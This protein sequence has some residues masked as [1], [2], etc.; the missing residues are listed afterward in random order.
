MKRAL[1][2]LLLLPFA[3]A[4]F[5]LQN[6]DI[7]VKLGEDGVASV[8]ERINLVIFGDYARQLYE[9]GYNRNT[10]SAWQEI[11]NVTEIKAHVSARS[12]DI[13]NLLILP[14][15]LRK[16][17]SGLDIWYGQIIMDYEAAPYYDKDG[18]AIND[19]GLVEADSYKPRTTRYTLNELS[20]NLPRTETGDIQ[21]GTNTALSLTPPQNAMLIYINPVPSDMGNVSLPTASR[22]LK[23]SGLTLVQFSVEYEVEESLDKEVLQ[24]FTDLQQQIRAMLV[25]QEG[26]AAAAIALILVL[27]FIYLRLSRR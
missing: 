23:W 24:F 17:P 16:S 12:S 5:Q 4:E 27:S 1:V 10:L 18:A 9:T 3:F 8:E 2:L 20:F 19:T 14:Q 26:A 6:M 22:T 21:L 13:R 11:T 7:S 15:P 25:S